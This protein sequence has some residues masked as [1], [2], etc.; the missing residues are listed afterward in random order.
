MQS[1][2]ATGRAPRKLINPPSILPEFI[3]IWEWFERMIGFRDSSF[4]ASLIRPSDMEAYFRLMWIEPNPMEVDV[5]MRID[6][7][8]VEFMSEEEKSAKT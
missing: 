5:L 8:F 6:Q 2:R 7:V 1:K 4:G 3:H